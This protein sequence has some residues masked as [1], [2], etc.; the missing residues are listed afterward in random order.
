MRTHLS[1]ATPVNSIAP[2]IV[3][4]EPDSDCDDGPAGTGSDNGDS[5]IAVPVLPAVTTTTPTTTTAAAAASITTTLAPV[6]FNVNSNNA[7]T[8]RV[9]N[10]DSVVLSLAATKSDDVD[11]TLMTSRGASGASETVLNMSGTVV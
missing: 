11:D 6:E 7:T 9:S 4:I 8:S 1:A 3:R 5:E 10:D 2:P